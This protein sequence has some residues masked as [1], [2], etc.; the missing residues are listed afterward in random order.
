MLRPGDVTFQPKPGGADYLS[1]SVFDVVAALGARRLLGIGSTCRAM[2]M[3]RTH[4]LRDACPV[5]GIS[6]VPAFAC[7]IVY[8]DFASNFSKEN[9]R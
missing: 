5:H 8:N 2:P 7:R 4:S 6:P 1:P 3:T 9:V